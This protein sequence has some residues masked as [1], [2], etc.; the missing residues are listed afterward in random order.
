[1]TVRGSTGPSN[2]TGE[3]QT[4]QNM[5]TVKSFSPQRSPQAAAAP[6]LPFATASGTTDANRAARMLGAGTISPGKRCPCLRRRIRCLDRAGPVCSGRKGRCGWRIR[7]TIGC[8]VGV[9]YRSLTVSLPIGSSASPILFLKVKMPREN[10]TIARL[11]YPRA[12]APAVREWRSP[13]PGTTGCCSGGRCPRTINVPA[14]MVL[15][16]ADFRQNL[17]NRGGEPSADPLHWPYGV[18]YHAGQL[19]VADTGNRRVLI[20]HQLPE[21]SGQPADRVLGQ[22]GFSTRN[23]NGGGTP[24]AASMRWPHSLAIW[25]GNLVLADAGNN[26]LTIWDGLPQENNQPCQAILGQANFQAVELNRGEYF[27]TDLSLNMPYGVAAAGDW[28]LAADT[29]NSRLVGWQRQGPLVPAELHDRPADGLFGQDTYRQKGENRSYGS[30]LRDSLCWPYGIQVCGQLAIVADSGNNRVAIWP[31]QVGL[32]GN[33]GM[34]LNSNRTKFNM[35]FSPSVTSKS[36]SPQTDFQISPSQGGQ[37]GTQVSPDVATCPQCLADTLDPF[38]RFYRY[39]FTNCTHCGPRLSIV[40][41]IPYD[42]HHTSMAA[43]SL[44][45]DCQKETDDPRDRRFTLG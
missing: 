27:P 22:A 21:R 6:R 18:M 28:L 35:L 40:R 24:T 26:R 5:I 31:L 32:M 8:W 25:Q 3:A 43:F 41:Q 9:T 33:W 34:H 4:G 12:F 7:A 19:Y 14:D 15:G 16:Q 30:A 20:W 37:S 1:M 13:M 10:P 11:P 44:C 2:R 38:S 23:E 17:P 42:R 29:A 45:P 39:P 36:S